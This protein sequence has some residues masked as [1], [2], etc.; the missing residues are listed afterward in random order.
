MQNVCYAQDK[1]S[2]CSFRDRLDTLQHVIVIATTNIE[3]P[4][5]GEMLPFYREKSFP[6]RVHAKKTKAELRSS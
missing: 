6:I 5:S 3:P 1:S 4:T 2:F